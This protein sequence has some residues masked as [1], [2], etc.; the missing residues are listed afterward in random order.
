M[1]VETLKPKLVVEGL[2]PFYRWQT[3]RVA[4]PAWLKRT[5]RWDRSCVSWKRQPRTRSR[6]CTPCFYCNADDTPRMR[7]VPMDTQGVST[8]FC[9]NTVTSSKTN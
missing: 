4:A 9:W 2:N 8:F 3:R 6:G 1:L 5:A 7:L